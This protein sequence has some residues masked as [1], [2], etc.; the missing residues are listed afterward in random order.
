MPSLSVFACSFGCLTWVALPSFLLLPSKQQMSANYTIA[1]WMSSMFLRALLSLL[2]TGKV[3][4]P[5][6]QSER[7]T[8]GGQSYRGTTARTWFPKRGLVSTKHTWYNQYA[9]TCRGYY[10]SFT[11]QTRCATVK[12]DIIR[13][14]YT[15]DETHSVKGGV[16][17]NCAISKNLR[18]KHPISPA[19]VLTITRPT[20][21]AGAKSASHCWCA[22]Q[23]L[24]PWR[25][26]SEALT[27]LPRPWV[28]AANPRRWMSKEKTERM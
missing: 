7:A 5:R 1:V 9:S 27:M 20:S 26:W 14:S 19:L 18:L 24:P 2:S 13:P 17:L 15:Q 21:Q 22:K 3:R 16:S 11:A 4:Q 23:Q 28:Q 12:P 25:L 8:S 10:V 6:N